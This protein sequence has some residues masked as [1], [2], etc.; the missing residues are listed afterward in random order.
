MKKLRVV[1]AEPG[2]RAEVREIDGSYKTMCAIV[3]GYLEV[4][5]VLWAEE[6][7]DCWLNENGRIEGLEPN[8]LVRAPRAD[9]WWDIYGT[10]FLA[11]SN[12]E[13]DTVS[14]GA[15]EAQALCDLLNGKDACP[16]DL[17]LRAA[18]FCRPLAGNTWED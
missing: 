6:G 1:V 5:P 9:S 8:R 17:L 15:D 12:E 10:L 7:L 2:Q 13:G 3:G 18:S 11:R 4:V 14:L 16:G